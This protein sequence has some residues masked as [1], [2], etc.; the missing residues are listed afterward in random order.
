MAAPP[1]EFKEL[2]TLPLGV[3][4]GERPAPFSRSFI[5]LTAVEAEELAPP[6]VFASRVAC[7]S[8]LCDVFFL[9]KRNDIVMLLPNSMRQNSR[10]ITRL[11]AQPRLKKQSE[12]E[13]QRSDGI[14]KCVG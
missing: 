10:M 9:P 1:V 11:Q 6:V 5:L 14:Q 4:F 3:G 8:G 7:G 12:G 2:L 13:L